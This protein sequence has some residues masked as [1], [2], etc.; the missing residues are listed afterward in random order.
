MIFPLVYKNIENSARLLLELWKEIIF[1]FSL[2]HKF[3]YK[4]SRKLLYQNNI[5]N[6]VLDGKYIMHYSFRN[7][8]KNL[9]HISFILI[10]YSNYKS[11][12]IPSKL[13]TL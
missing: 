6:P 8:K 13:Y 10:A 12:E 2:H 11:F 7:F 3:C 9:Q 1:L 5:F 4:T